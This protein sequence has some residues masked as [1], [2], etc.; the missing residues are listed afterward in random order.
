MGIDPKKPL[1]IL[2]AM[3][4]AV[5]VRSE[6]V[7]RLRTL[8]PQGIQV[9][10]WIGRQIRE[11]AANGWVV[12]CNRMSHQGIL[13]WD[14]SSLTPIPYY[15]PWKNLEQ[16]REAWNRS[17]PYYQPLIEPRGSYGEGEFEA[18]W[19]DMLFRMGWIG[20]VPEF[21]DLSRQAIKDILESRDE[22]GYIGVNQ[23]RIRFTGTA[24]APFGVRSG[25]GEIYGTGELLGALLTYY[26]LTGDERVL[27]AVTKAAD[28]TIERTTDQWRLKNLS[29]YGEGYG[30][31][32]T[33]LYRAT[34]KK[35]YLDKAR[36]LVNSHVQTDFLP[37]LLSHEQGQIRGHS[38]A[39]GMTLL[40]MLDLYHVTGDVD[41]LDW[42]RKINDRVERFSLQSHGAPTGQLEWL[43]KSSPRVNTEGCDIF[44]FA[45]TWIEMLKATGD[46]HY[47]DL[48]EKAALNAL[49]GHR[50]KDGA[51]A[52]YFS[53]PNELFATRGS[54]MGTVYSARMFV[55]CCHGNLGRLLPVL[56]ENI[57]LGTPEGNYAIPFY[58][59]STFRDNSPK[60]G[61]I[62]IVQETDYPFSDKV[63]IMVRTERPAAFSVRMRMPG[64][65]KGARVRIN[66]RETPVETKESWLD[67]N[68]TWGA[69]DVVEL[70]LP[71]ETRVTIDKDGAAVVQRG[72]LVYALPVEGRRI[73][74]DQWGSFEELVT[75]DSKWNYALVL[76]KANPAKSFT[77]KELPVPEKAKVWEL[78][79]VALEVEAVRVPEWKFD[80]DPA[81]LI[82]SKTENVPEPPFPAQ[83]IKVTGPR[84]KIR[85]VPYGCTILR[86]TQLPVADSRN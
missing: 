18:H 41:M 42:A 61:H 2:V 72:P 34:R 47:A 71:M 55:E 5:G 49:P 21:R 15:L 67:L 16:G 8:P 3:L 84:E 26:R 57:V 45:W 29:I 32:W 60:A 59:S 28:L 9:D 83:P 12:T 73:Q 4:C 51:V 24:T 38:A 68:R 81:L 10:G 35:E 40:E 48:A 85:L 6:S 63:K 65:C 86:M 77:F 43:E 62:E 82:P 70:T 1:M 50:S 37:Q 69:S 56:S 53:R 64:W 27:K 79:R 54:H 31:P 33:S 19:L 17:V 36:A 74:V 46:A 76:D 44:W 14:A 7:E 39:T 22:T 20:N 52:P 78:P 80:K 66:G 11:D 30:L 25:E 23:P 75:V 13:G 58:N